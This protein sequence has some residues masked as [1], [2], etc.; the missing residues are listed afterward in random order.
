MDPQNAE[1]RDDKE[2]FGHRLMEKMGWK[3]GKGLGAEEQGVAENIRLKPTHGNRGLGAVP[4]KED[5]AWVGH[6]DDFAKLL[7]E[8]NAKKARTETVPITTTTGPTT[9]ECTKP[10]EERVD[11]HTGSS[12]R[13]IRSRLAKVKSEHRAAIFG[14]STQ[15]SECVKEITETSELMESTKDD[16]PLINDGFVVSKV[17]TSD[18]FKA[19][20]EALKS[21]KR[22]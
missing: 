17:S 14:D 16:G 5:N 7:S 19:K 10:Q 21:R 3:E 15:R 18:Y 2:K 8:L 12:R 20:M 22:K 6:H 1:W 4:S 13:T 11:G 9:E